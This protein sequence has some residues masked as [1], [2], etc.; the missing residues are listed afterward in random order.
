MSPLFPAQSDRSGRLAVAIRKAVISKDP[1]LREGP[2]AQ[3]LGSNENSCGFSGLWTA[4]RTGCVPVI[5]PGAGPGSPP[6]HPA[7]PQGKHAPRRLGRRVGHPSSEALGC[8][9][10]PGTSYL[11]VLFGWE[12]AS[13]GGHRAQRFMPFCLL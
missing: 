4:P 6:A 7:T 2:T 10:S 8:P 1:F 12:Q 5:N 11:W 13:W 3:K 9:E